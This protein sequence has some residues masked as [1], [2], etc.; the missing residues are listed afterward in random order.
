MISTAAVSVVLAGAAMG[1]A[2]AASADTPSGSYTATVTQRGG[3]VRVGMT[4]TVTFTP[5]GPDCLKQRVEGTGATGD[6]RR[7]GD[8]WVGPLTAANGDVCTQTLADNLVMTQDCPTHRVV[9][10]LTKNG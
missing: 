4:A 3:G 2:A 1:W 7:Q 6:M 10:Q 8:T 9:M 5:C